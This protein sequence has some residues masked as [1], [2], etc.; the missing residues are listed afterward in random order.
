MTSP[1]PIV[2]TTQVF[3]DTG[4]S[5]AGRWQTETMAPITGATLTNTENSYGVVD[6]QGRVVSVFPSA[7]RTTTQTS[8][9]LYS[10]NATYLVATMVSTAKGP[11]PSL[12]MAIQAYDAPSAT[13]ISVLTSAAIVTAAPTTT[14][15]TIGP[16]VP[17]VANVSQSSVLPDMVRIVVTVSN[18]DSMTYSVGLDWM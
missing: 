8:G 3:T 12:T 13:W 10:R 7:A 11:A 6:Q 2:Q 16:A 1:V 15:L 17:I 9:T 18:S 14:R 5:D 4:L